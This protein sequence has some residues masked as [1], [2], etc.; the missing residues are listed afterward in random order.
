MGQGGRQEADVGRGQAVGPDHGPGLVGQA[1]VRVEHGLGLA[2]RARREQDHGDVGPAWPRRRSAGGADSRSSKRAS[3]PRTPMASTS[4]A[5]GWPGVLRATAG[6]EL[7]E[8]PGHFG[9]P[10]L[11]VDG[12]GHRSAPPAGPEEHHRLPPVGQ[13]PGHHAP[14][15]DTQPG[16]AARRRGHQPLEGAGI[17]PHVAVH[18]GQTVGRAARAEESVEGG[19]V[20]GPPGLAVARRAGLAVG[21]AEPHV[22]ISGPRGQRAGTDPSTASFSDSRT[23]GADL[24]LGMPSCSSAT[25]YLDSW[26]S[27][28]CEWLSWWRVKQ[29]CRE[30]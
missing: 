30:L 14:P 3:P 8:D 6:C 22:V 26:I 19:H 5:S 18:D 1:P 10:H 2:G 11:V 20:P 25:G 21:G 13:L 23:G 16:Q 17:Q 9:R 7:V 4:P 15:P 27:A 12:G 28:Q 29:A 24:Q